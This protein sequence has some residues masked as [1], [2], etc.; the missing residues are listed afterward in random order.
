MRWSQHATAPGLAIPGDAG[1][2][3]RSGH[4]DY[5]YS[6]SAALAACRCASYGSNMS[7]AST[8]REAPLHP[9]RPIPGPVDRESFFA[10]QARN[11][12]ATWRLGAV[13]VLAVLLMG[14]PL[15][16]VVSPLVWAAFF[17]L[18]DIVNRIT[19]TPDLLRRRMI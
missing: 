12:R 17:L 3:R 2:S 7:E 16:V 10:A 6:R 11:R 9:W 5:Q 18:N 14:I 4:V 15:S 1:F 8:G 13:G 19:P